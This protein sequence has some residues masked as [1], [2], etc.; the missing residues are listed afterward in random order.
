MERRAQSLSCSA[1]QA[2]LLGPPSHLLT[3][4]IP[5]FLNPKGTLAIMMKTVALTLATPPLPC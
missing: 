4:L 1:N 2:L 3:P 5:G